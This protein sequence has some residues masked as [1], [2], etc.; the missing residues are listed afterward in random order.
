MSCRRKPGRHRLRRLV[1]QALA[2]VRAAFWTTRHLEMQCC[3]VRSSGVRWRD[4]HVKG[5]TTHSCDGDEIT[6][7]TGGAGTTTMPSPHSKTSKR[8]WESGQG[9]NLKAKRNKAGG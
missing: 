9:N 1:V 4:E 8:T 3:R 7:G 2:L 5:T 6:W